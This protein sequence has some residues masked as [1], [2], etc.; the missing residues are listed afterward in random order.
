MRDR[1]ARAVY[2]RNRILD[3]LSTQA[4]SKNDDLLVSWKDIAA[5]LKCSVRKAQ[6]LERRELPVKRIAGTKSVWASKAEIDR[7]FASE[8]EKTKSLQTQFGGSAVTSRQTSD[9][10]R[11]TS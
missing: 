3:V 7:W 11:T 9:H 8:A 6:R 5:Y 10:S 4:E 1:L 2:E